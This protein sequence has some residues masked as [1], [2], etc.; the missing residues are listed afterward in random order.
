MQLHCV[1]WT[2]ETEHGQ[3]ITGYEVA[4][5][6][7]NQGELYVTLP[8]PLE[9]SKQISPR[10]GF[11]CLKMYFLSCIAKRPAQTLSSGLTTSTT[12]TATRG[13]CQASLG[14]CVKGSFRH[15]DINC[16]IALIASLQYETQ[17]EVWFDYVP[18]TRLLHRLFEDVQSL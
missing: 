18:S 8:S 6:L 13:K 4:A 10:T 5:M 12:V 14:A 15:L 7:A 9:L 11:K 3:T 16:F 1:V 2:G 17:Q